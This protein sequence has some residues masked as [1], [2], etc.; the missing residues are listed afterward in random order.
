V[1]GRQLAPE[2][3]EQTVFVEGLTDWEFIDNRRCSV[4]D[5]IRSH[6]PSSTSA[7]ICVAYLSPSGFRTI[8]HELE[9]FL[10]KGASLSIIS[11]EEIS[12]TDAE[13]LLRL[14]DRYPQIQAKIYPTELT[15]MH[16]K[17]YLLEEND[18]AHVLAGSSN[19]TLGGLKTN[20]ESNLAGSFSSAQEMVRQ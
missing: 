8:E 13:F 9:H 5:W 12:K 7:S 1:S 20:I 3:D 11:S 10:N 6:L 2:N 15:F 16:S 19:L 17:V 14:A 4:A 18:K